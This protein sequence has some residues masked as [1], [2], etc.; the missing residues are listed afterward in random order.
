[1]AEHSRR[2]TPEGCPLLH[3]FVAM[4]MDDRW[5]KRSPATMLETFHWFHGEGFHMIIDD[6]LRLPTNLRIIVEG[7]RLLPHLVE[8]ILSASSHAVWLLPS[9]EFRESTLERR[10]GRTWGF[11]AKTSDSE[12]ALQNLI[13]RDRMFTDRL[14]QEIE[15]LKLHAIE[16]HSAMN[17][18]QT[19]SSVAEIFGL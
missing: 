16:V 12:R 13:E 6:L 8:P 19:T 15:R 17:E 14:R 11:L 18:D 4:S 9:P 3:E 5:V 7:F 1:M 2:S 10:G